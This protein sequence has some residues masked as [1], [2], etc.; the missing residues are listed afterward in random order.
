MC[1]RHDGDKV[2][3]VPDL[4]GRE[5]DAEIHTIS[6]ESPAGSNLWHAGGLLPEKCGYSGRKPRFSGVDCD[7]Y[8]GGASSVETSDVGINSRRNDMLY[9]VGADGILI[10]RSMKNSKHII[11]MSGSLY[12]FP[13]SASSPYRT[14][15]FFHR[16]P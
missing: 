9:A 3:A 11:L 16:D 8:Y 15:V 2:S 4:Q 12:R 10:G 7:S 1:F 6:W 14:G 13:P 5:A